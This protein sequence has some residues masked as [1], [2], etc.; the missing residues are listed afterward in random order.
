MNLSIDTTGFG[1]IIF[2]LDNQSKKISKTFAVIPQ[3]SN[4]IL[5]YLNNFL[6][7]SKIKNPS[8][9]IEKIILYKKTGTG[10]TGLRI[11]SAIAQALS[12]AWQVP[13]KI[14]KKF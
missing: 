14:Q 5:A 7:S 9:E 4:R 12:F 6:K 10:F 2:V 8:K 13:V 3:E 11:A 1:K